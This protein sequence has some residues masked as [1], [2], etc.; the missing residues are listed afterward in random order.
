[1][2]LLFVSSQIYAAVIHEGAVHPSA[3]CEW[4][5]EGE[6][7]MQLRDPLCEHVVTSITEVYVWDRLSKSPG[8]GGG[9]AHVDGLCT[10]KST[11]GNTGITE[12]HSVF[13]V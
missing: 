2:C 11:P 3:C 13:V 9:K 8:W 7:V 10:S 6:G 1:M 5:R 12:K 4:E